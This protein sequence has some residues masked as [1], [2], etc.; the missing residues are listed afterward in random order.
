MG[1]LAGTE[2]ANWIA[3]HDGIGRHEPP[4]K[5]L[6]N[7]AHQYVRPKND[8]DSE[9][10]AGD[11][12]IVSL[13]ACVSRVVSSRPCLTSTGFVTG[14]RLAHKPL[15]AAELEARSSG[16][17]GPEPASRADVRPVPAV[18]AAVVTAD[19]TPNRVH[20]GVRAAD[21]HPGHGECGSTLGLD[22]R[23]LPSILGPTDVAMSHATRHHPPACRSITFNYRRTSCSS[24]TAWKPPNFPGF[25]VHER[26]RIWPHYESVAV[27][28]GVVGRASEASVAP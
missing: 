20:G 8:T 4:D 3:Q 26:A 18:Q 17:D 16:R 5:V 1:R 19:S 10:G 22:E 28:V 6:C 9:T 21:P 23:W 11:E 25:E 15:T 27:P 13:D 7:F 12:G 2:K 24:E 14:H